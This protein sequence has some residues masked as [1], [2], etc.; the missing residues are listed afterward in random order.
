MTF[1]CSNLTE[2]CVEGGNMTSSISC[3]DYNGTNTTS[4]TSTVPTF[5]FGAAPTRLEGLTTLM[6]MG[7]GTIA[8]IGL[9]GNGLVIFVIMKYSKM[10]TVTNMYILNLS[11]ADSLFLIG[12]PLIMTTVKVES[13]IFGYFLCKLY[14]ILTCINMFTGTF[15]L[16]AM[17]ADRFLAVCFPIQAITART[18]RNAIIIIVLIWIFS[19]IFMLPVVLYTELVPKWGFADKYSCLIMW[20]TQLGTPGQNIFITYTLLLGFVI[21][22]IMISILYTLLVIR[23]KTTGSQAQSV[24]RRTSHRKVTKLVTIIIMVFFVCWLPYWVF[25]VLLVV[26]PPKQKLPI[27]QVYIFQVF[28]ILSYANSMIN[29][30]LY[31]FTNENFREA[32]INAFKCAADPLGGASANNRRMQS[33]WESVNPNMSEPLRVKRDDQGKDSRFLTGDPGMNGV[34]LRSSAGETEISKVSNGD[35]SGTHNVQL[36]SDDAIADVQV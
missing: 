21:P 26:S 13:W 4:N 14:Y 16:T 11:V 5:P 8:T 10:K 32:F 23:L 20:P 33:D 3:S 35:P 7:Y 22:I 27:W 29:P 34:P 12:L 6:L 9:L 15:T 28:T 2:C 36:N 30:L 25:Q 31:A 24:R 17:S 18:P 1:L 19:F